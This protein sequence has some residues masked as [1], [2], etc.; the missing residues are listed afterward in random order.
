MKTTAYPFGT[1]RYIDDIF[2][3][4]TEGL[5]NLNTFVNYLNNLHPTIKFTS[6]HS[7][8]NI[9]FLDLMVSLKDGLIETDLY[10]KP[11]DKHHEYLI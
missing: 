8:A 3:I 6:N 2:M 1:W 4:W 11:T 7:F 9:P 10:T 5:E